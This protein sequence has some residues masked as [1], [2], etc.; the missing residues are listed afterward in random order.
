VWLEF[1]NSVRIHFLP[2][3][4][5]IF[6]GVWPLDQMAVTRKKRGISD[7]DPSR[8]RHSRLA[9]RSSLGRPC[10]YQLVELLRRRRPWSAQDGACD[11][12]LGSAV[13]RRIPTCFA[14]IYPG[15]GA[16]L[17]RLIDA[18]KVRGAS[19]STETRYSSP[20]DERRTS[21]SIAQ[22]G[23]Y[24][25]RIEHSREIRSSISSRFSQAVRA[26]TSEFLFL[27]P[28]RGVFFVADCTCLTW[29]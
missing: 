26:V 13:D 15:I 22:G 25:G 10:G 9:C 19:E 16:D 1:G 23:L 11:Q 7:L 14:C 27:P 29:V 21:V 5:A 6:Q 12:R 20:T 17:L 2:I 8:C 18:F 4:R 24:R 3:D 28:I